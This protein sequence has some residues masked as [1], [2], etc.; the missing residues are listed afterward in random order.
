MDVDG[1]RSTIKEADSRQF[2]DAWLKWRGNRMVPTRDDMDLGDI[3]SNLGTLVLFDVVGPDDI[4]F[5]LCGSRLRMD[6]VIDV[7]PTG[8]NYKDLTSPEDWPARSHR[9]MTMSRHP[10]GGVMTLR[11]QGK[12]DGQVAHL[13]CVNLPIATSADPSVP[14]QLICCN[15]PLEPKL[16]MAEPPRLR[17]FP[18]VSGFVFV[19]IGAGVAEH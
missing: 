18:A 17:T 16:G 1:L 13:E 8:R 11:L 4:M 2:V 5:R 7:E 14:C 3:K 19:D 12:H 9:F 10:C 15:T 6:D